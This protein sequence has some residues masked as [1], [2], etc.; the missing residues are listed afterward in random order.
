MLADSVSQIAIC[1]AAFRAASRSA[2]TWVTTSLTAL[3]GVGLAQPGSG[4]D[5]LG[6]VRFDHRG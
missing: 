2:F 5:D 3:L 6:H 1:M 4:S